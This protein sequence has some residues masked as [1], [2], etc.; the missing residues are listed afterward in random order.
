LV[1]DPESKDGVSECEPPDGGVCDDWHMTRKNSQLHPI[2]RFTSRSERKTE[3]E[4]CPELKYRESSESYD[5]TYI[6]SPG[7]SALKKQ[8]STTNTSIYHF[9]GDKN[10]DRQ[11][12]ITS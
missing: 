8:T 9:T 5:T 11:N 3:G 4:G 10:G 12:A 2:I 7:N 6:I 1:F